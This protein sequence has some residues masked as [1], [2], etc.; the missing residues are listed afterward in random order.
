MLGFDVV[1][2][3]CLALHSS[4]GAGLIQCYWMRPIQ[5]RVMGLDEEQIELD[6]IAGVDVAV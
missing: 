2:E 6:G 4:E 1:A 3:L 5:D